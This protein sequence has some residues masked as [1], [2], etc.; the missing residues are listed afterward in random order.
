M[1]TFDH[2]TRSLRLQV[3]FNEPPISFRLNGPPCTVCLNFDPRN[4]PPTDGGSRTSPDRVLLQQDYDI[5]RKSARSGCTF[6][7]LVR[8]AISDV[9]VTSHG[10]SL[11]TV[12][13][14][15]QEPQRIR[16]RG[17][18]VRALSLCPGLTE[19]F[20]P[21]RRSM[22]VS[23]SAESKEGM[24]YLRYC[25]QACLAS[26]AECVL[27][28]STTPSRLLSLGKDD[29]QIRIVETTTGEASEYAALSRCW[30]GSSH[31]CILKLANERSM[32][33][34]V[35][36]NSLPRTYRDAITVCRELCLKYLWIDSLYSARR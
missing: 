36:W 10:R 32:K 12:E 26:H 27:D 22:Q 17:R 2:T 34:P 28:R 31:L 25:Y 14:K 15:A 6:C 35:H 3:P 24:A 1:Q 5:Y 21:F 18:V 11:M 19:T 4:D 9:S 13:L 16:S 20:G 7:A 33:L 8:D 29:S 30:G 23:A